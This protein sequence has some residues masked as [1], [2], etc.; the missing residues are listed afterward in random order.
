[1]VNII[2][3]PTYFSVHGMLKLKRKKPYEKQY[4]FTSR[5]FDSKIGSIQQQKVI[6]L[7]T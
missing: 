2:D 6:H 3:N 4:C 5:S 7:E 1:M